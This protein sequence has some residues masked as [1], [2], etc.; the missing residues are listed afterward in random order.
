MFTCKQNIPHARVIKTQHLKYQVKTYIKSCVLDMF[1]IIQSNPFSY[2]YNPSSIRF[3]STTNP[4]TT[5]NQT[6]VLATSNAKLIL[7]SFHALLSAKL[8]RDERIAGGRQIIAKRALF[9]R[10]QV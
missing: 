6:L 9:L 4:K 2:C 1:Q 5:H 3:E 10:F 7:L 8:F